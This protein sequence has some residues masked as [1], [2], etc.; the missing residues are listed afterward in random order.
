MDIDNATDF[1]VDISINGMPGLGNVG[2]SRFLRLKLFRRRSSALICRKSKSKTQTAHR[3]IVFGERK[4]GDFIVYAER[5]NISATETHLPRHEIK[6]QDNNVV[7]TA[8]LIRLNVSKQTNIFDIT[9]NALCEL[10]SART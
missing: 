9:L 4:D 7:L 1:K 5:N 10:C 2:M 6:F 8:V 3:E